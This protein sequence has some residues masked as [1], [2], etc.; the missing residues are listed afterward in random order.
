MPRTDLHTFTVEESKRILSAVKTR[1][2]PQYTISHLTQAAVVLAMLELIGA[3]NVSDDD[4]F[5][6]GM[7]VNGRRFLD[8]KY[9]KKQY[10]MCETCAVIKVEKLKSLAKS[11]EDKQAAIEALTKASSDV[12]KCLDRWLSNPSQLQ[13]GVSMHNLEAS[14]LSA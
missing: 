3:D 10:N 9:A 6:H 1:L 7:P 2:G 4:F 14:F 8:E 13:L 5:V 12:K 11:K